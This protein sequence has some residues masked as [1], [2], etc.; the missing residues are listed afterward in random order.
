[1]RRIV[2]KLCDCR[3]DKTLSILSNVIQLVAVGGDA[4]QCYIAVLE[5]FGM[6]SHHGALH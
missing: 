1:M 4:M 2:A 3:S 5:S 6:V